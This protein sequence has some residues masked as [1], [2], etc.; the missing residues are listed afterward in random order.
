MAEEMYDVHY[1][2]TDSDPAG[3]REFRDGEDVASWME[4]VGIMEWTGPEDGDL[5]HQIDEVL[6]VP[7][8]AEE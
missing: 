4:R 2:G 5:D 1:S 3:E 8:G 7:E 6:E